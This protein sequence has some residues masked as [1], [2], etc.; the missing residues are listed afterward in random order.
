MKG[1]YA[2]RVGAGLALLFA[3]S[4]AV[5]QEPSP[6]APDLDACIAAALEDNPGLDAARA[7]VQAA[8]ALSAQARAAVSPQLTASGSYMRTDNPPQAFM[9]DLNRRALDMS[10]P[11]FN[12]NDP[13]DTDHV[14]WSLGARW[15]LLDGGRR[16]AGIAASGRMAGALAAR[17]TAARRELVHEV[18]R[19]YFGVLQARALG[20]IQ[21]E[22]IR[23]LGE[24][25]RLARARLDA[26]SAVKTDVLNLEVKLAEADEGRLR[27]LN[28][29]EI[30][31]LALNTAIGRE[32]VPPGGPAPF[33]ME[34]PPEAAPPEGD[35]SVR[36]ELEAAR[37]A[38]EARAAMERG[39]R[40]EY[41][42][43]LNA[44]GSLDWDS[45]RFNDYE[46]SYLAGLAVEWEL[47]SGGRR[48]YA[49]AE[50]RARLREAAAEERAAHDGVRL[51]IA[52]ADAEAREARA[53]YAVAS[54]AEE[55]ADESLR[56]T[57]ERYERGGADISELLNAETAL[58]SA[59]IRRETARYETFVA[60]AN[61]RRARGLE[62][63][64]FERA[65]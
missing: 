55:S 1:T 15:R 57:R 49:V 8:E 28:A 46:R 9:M 14:R 22:A 52:R 19:G 43:V 59:R 44:F 21:D 17:E 29:E 18:T 54:K 53:R 11:S 40:A 39:A 60:Q 48:V 12:P 58:L 35:G 65:P 37:L 47:F 45:D 62:G 33:T 38:R 63:S 23:S 34:R 7:R 32:L 20:R 24:S 30:A 5:A 61:Q 13:D 6:A 10:D 4:A 31:R 27:A 3:G 16:A 2:R 26:G 42:P 36:A 25:L 51:D 41:R 50:A 56:I 64:G